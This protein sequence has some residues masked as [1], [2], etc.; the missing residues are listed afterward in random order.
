ML[1]INIEK[2]ISFKTAKRSFNLKRGTYVYIGS[3]MKNLYQ[4]V[5]RHISYKEGSYKKNWHIDNLLENGEVIRV[6]LIPDGKYREIEISKLFNSEF[7]AVKGFG[8]SDIKELES[9]LY[10]IE[11]LKKAYDLIKDIK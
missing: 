1:F 5:G 10:Y 3:A 2:D 6:F 9:N 4:R 8:A 7:S 11:D